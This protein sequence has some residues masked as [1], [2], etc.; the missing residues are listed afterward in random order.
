MAV[1]DNEKEYLQGLLNEI[2]RIKARNGR[3]LYRI[4]DKITKRVAR[5][6]ERYFRSTSDYF[7]EMRKCAMCTNAWDVII[8]FR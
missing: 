1:I 8:R 7:I 2:E 6:V 4:N 3:T 5:S